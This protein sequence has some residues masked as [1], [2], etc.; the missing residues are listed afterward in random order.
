MRPVV[1]EYIAVEVNTAHGI[2][3]TLTCWKCCVQIAHW[4]QNSVDLR[5]LVERADEHIALAHR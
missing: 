2:S 4:S 5:E 3:H 1:V